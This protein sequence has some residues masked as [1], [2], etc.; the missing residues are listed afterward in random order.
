MLTPGHIL[1]IAPDPSLRATREG[2]LQDAGYAVTSL[3]N[4]SE[5]LAI[6]GGERIAF[7]IL[8]V[9]DCTPADER[10]RLIATLKAT[11][12]HTPVLVIGQQREPLSDDVMHGLNGP[13]ALLDRVARLLL[14]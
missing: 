13:Q 4:T 2:I 7:D 9:C 6:I 3:S 5:A 8:I 12:P 11:S 14:I 10:S 1:S